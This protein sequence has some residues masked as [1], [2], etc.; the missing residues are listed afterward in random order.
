MSRL[1]LDVQRVLRLLAC[2]VCIA[3]TSSCA[4]PEPLTQI[5]VVIDSDFSGLRRIEAELGGFEEPS[6]VTA[7]LDDAPLPR[8]FSIVH[9]GGELGPISVTVRAYAGE[10]DQPL[11][12]EPRTDMFFVRGQ[13]LLLKV[14]LLEACIGLCDAREACV[15]PG[16]CVPS[17][18]AAQL[19]PW[20]GPPDG[21][22]VGGPYDAGMDAAI[23]MPDAAP[24]DADT[25][26]APRDVMSPEPD[27]ELEDASDADALI[28][29][30][31][32]DAG[33]SS[34]PEPVWSF[35]PSNVA[36]D[37]ADVVGLERRD[38]LLNCGLSEINSSDVTAAGFCDDPPPDMIVIPRADGDVLVVVMKS[39]E[40]AA[41]STLRVRGSNPVVFLIEGDVEIAGTLDA[42]AVGSI[43]GP[44]AGRDCVSL[45]GVAGGSDTTSGGRGGSGGGGGGY[46]T[47]GAASG[48]SSTMVSA[49]G[50]GVSS[51]ATYVPLRGGCGGGP[52]GIGAA[53][54]VPAAGGGGGGAIQ[55]SVAGVLTLSGVIRAAGGG[56]AAGSGVQGGG[57]GGGS[58]GTVAL[59]ALTF[60]ID[61][62]AVIAVNGGAGG[63]GQPTTAPDVTST[64]GE[65]GT[66]STTPATPGTGNNSGGDGGAGSALGADASPGGDGAGYGLGCPTI[67]CN[68]GGGGGGAGGLGR[69]AVRGTTTCAPQ[70]I[71][72]PAP[73]V[74][75]EACG[76]CPAMPDLSCVARAQAPELYAI[77][78]AQTEWAIARAAC[79]AVDLDLAQI[80][81]RAEHDFLVS[82]LPASTWFWFGAADVVE[83][84]WRWVAD[85]SQF[86][87]GASDGAAVGAAFTAWRAGDPQSNGDCGRFSS[88]GWADQQCDLAYGY[89]CKQ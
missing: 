75:C 71:F 78:S 30:E 3:F 6:T 21:L 74:Q 70:G 72:S 77:C 22:S 42:S 50:G 8:R 24:E 33:D 34:T 36:L 62:A 55:L 38:V 39:L 79:Q 56:G 58:G 52:G 65:D 13:T 37:D 7:D 82:Q 1:S 20:S 83:G 81:S 28:D 45:F 32:E 66:A 15:D 40:I 61:P 76:A 68:Y 35:E 54:A 80:T 25:S 63:G 51:S 87:S 84:D 44:G 57:G 53:G 41:G 31:P 60:A 14:D 67:G 17:D 27:A 69:I 2:T 4:D 48:A 47:P 10:D 19:V 23:N 11:L 18:E 59:E 88:S 86:W 85:N 64:A 16:E 5:V 26:D 46:G 12:V 43:A 49:A 73:S 89:V 29:A 9:D